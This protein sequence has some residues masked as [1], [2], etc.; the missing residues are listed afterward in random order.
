MIYVPCRTCRRRR[1]CRDASAM[2]R[3]A[4]SAWANDRTSPE[5]SEYAPSYLRGVEG[6]FNPPRP[7]PAGGS[8]G[9]SS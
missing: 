7:L 8:R 3:M 2:Y 6:V 9:V 1:G 5:C 4:G